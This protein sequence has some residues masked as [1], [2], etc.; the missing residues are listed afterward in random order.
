MQILHILLQ[1]PSLEKGIVGTLV[2]ATVGL[3]MSIIGFKVVDW[4]TPGNLA[5]Q[6]GEG[7]NMAIALVASALILGICI[8]IAA[9]IAS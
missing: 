9:S 8:I 2:Y 3:I 5:K 6:I 7:K 1:V 4:I